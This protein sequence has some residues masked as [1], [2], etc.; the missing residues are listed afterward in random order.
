[1]GRWAIAI[2][3]ALLMACSPASSP[4]EAALQAQVGALQQQLQH[5]SIGCN[6]ST[7]DFRT[8][9]MYLA[10]TVDGQFIVSPVSAEANL[11][12]TKLTIDLVNPYA[13]TWHDATITATSSQHSATDTVSGDFSP[14]VARRVEITIPNLPPDQLQTVSVDIA[15]GGANWVAVGPAP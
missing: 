13:V 14:G 9:A 6:S 5:A 7:V 11:G 12:G 4:N 15:F 8:H 1:M 10:C 3:A 2:S